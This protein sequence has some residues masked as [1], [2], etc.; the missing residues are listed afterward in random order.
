MSKKRKNIFLMKLSSKF[1]TKK[2]THFRKAAM[3]PFRE[4]EAFSTFIDLEHT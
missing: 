2:G 4:S 1:K 3:F